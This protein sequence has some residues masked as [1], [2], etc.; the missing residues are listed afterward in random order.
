MGIVCC[1]KEHLT[2]SSIRQD[3]RNPNG[4]IDFLPLIKAH[5]IGFEAHTLAYTQK[6]GRADTESRWR[7]SLAFTDGMLLQMLVGI[8]A[9]FFVILSL[10][11]FHRPCLA[12]REG[13]CNVGMWEY[14]NEK[15]R[16]GENGGMGWQMEAFGRSQRG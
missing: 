11:L 3:C 9:A 6:P 5:A 8:A 1:R 13:K 16:K 2:P 7:C 14:E 15:M 10:H 4:K 12:G